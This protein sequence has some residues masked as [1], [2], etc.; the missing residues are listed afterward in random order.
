[1]STDALRADSPAASELAT[2]ATWLT[3][4]EARRGWHSREASHPRPHSVSRLRAEP[5]LGEPCRCPPN[6]IAGRACECNGVLAIADPPLA[7]AFV[8][9]GEQSAVDRDRQRPRLAGLEFSALE[10][11]Q[12]HALI[13]GTRFARVSRLRVAQDRSGGSS[14]PASEA[15]PREPAVGRAQATVKCRP[16]LARLQT[17]SKNAPQTARNGSGSALAQVLVRLHGDQR[18]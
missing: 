17:G 9:A 13:T 18:P 4:K 10:A 8:E 7:W 1:M 5:R 12:P 15:P 3:D 11:E 14:W 2:R 6:E 16:P